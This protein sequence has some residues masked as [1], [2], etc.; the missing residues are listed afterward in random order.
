LARLREAPL[1]RVADFLAANALF[2][3]GPFPVEEYHLFSSH[4]GGNGSHYRIEES[5][6]LNRRPGKP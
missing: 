5:Y 4:A 3:S 6:G 1:D 2:L